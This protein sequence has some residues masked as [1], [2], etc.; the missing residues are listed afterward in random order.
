MQQEQQEQQNFEKNTSLVYRDE[1]YGTR[2]VSRQ[3]AYATANTT[4]RFAPTQTLQVQ[5]TV[6]QNKQKTVQTA[7][8]ESDGKTM[9]GKTA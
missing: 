8:I 7:G 2:S 1:F 6:A 4:Q 5:S 9:R 3:K